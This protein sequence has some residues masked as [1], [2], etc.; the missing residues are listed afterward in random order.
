MRTT[1]KERESLP[2]F[3][4]DHRL[5]DLSASGK[6]LAMEV[7]DTLNKHYP[8]HLWAVTVDEDGG[9]LVVKNLALSGNWG[10][11]FH[12]NKLPNGKSIRPAVVRAGGELL[13]RYNLSR[14][15]L[16]RNEVLELKRDFRGVPIGDFS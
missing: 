4:K 5:L 14:G 16:I 12:L 7:G 15:R 13:E 6:L 10:F 1:A 2:E 3:V 11:V 9:V 8:G